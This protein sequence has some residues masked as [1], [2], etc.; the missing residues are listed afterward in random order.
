MVFLGGAGCGGGGGAS[1]D[2]RPGLDAVG[3]ADAGAGMRDAV[4]DKSSDASD[5]G[6]M[7][8]PPMT[9]PGGQRI[10][11]GTVNFISN[12][13]P[14]SYESGSTADVWCAILRP[15][16]QQV[17][18]SALFI[19]N[20][21][22]AVAGTPVA[23][24]TAAG[25]PNCL[26]LT[27]GFA[28]DDTH[29][30]G[31]QGSTLIYYDVTGTPY[32]WRPGMLNGRRLVRVTFDTGDA[33]DC[34]AAPR[35]DAV[36]CLQDVPP[37]ILPT[38]GVPSGS[39]TATFSDLLVGHAGPE[40][41]LLQKVETI[42]SHDTNDSAQRALFRFVGPTGDHIAWSTP[43]RPGAPEVLK[44]QIVGDDASRQVVA[45]DVSR[46]ATSPDFTQWA[47]LS[48]FN[49]DNA[50]PSGTLQ[51]APF[52]DGQAPLTVLEKAATFYFVK[53]HGM[54][55]LDDAGHLF[56]VVDT[57]GSSK[58]VMVPLDNGVLGVIAA[59]GDGHLAYVKSF[60]FIF[61]LVDLYVQKYDGTGTGC[62][63][64]R[65]EE[66]PYGG[67]LGPRFLSNSAALLW[68]RVTNLDTNDD[69]LKAAGKFTRTTD[70]VTQTVG[71]DIVA[72]GPLGQD[73]ISVSDSYDGSSG[74]LRIRGLVSTGDMLAP[75]DPI[76]VQTRMDSSLSLYPLLHALVYTVNIGD[77][78]DGLYF[79][80][81]SS[82]TAPAP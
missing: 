1:P 24:G 61:S 28:S 36:A 53:D 59:S 64:D 20:I 74:T 54:S 15:S 57:T 67:S 6:L 18:S 77:S 41:P 3:D 29:K 70:C 8:P 75:G 47:W 23:C 78:A 35:G 80:P 46:W 58:P 27:G 56:G 25:D 62:S 44:M 31:F 11:P 81:V 50:A 79:R 45:T 49:Y 42:V 68:A 66:V 9:G 82:P 2:S 4:P 69:R 71:S 52:P 13:V 38:G 39:T 63:L 65:S 26:L 32:A 51:V 19:M 21:S 48:G 73:G 55:I 7:L 33:H 17:G 40:A 37:V 30:A 10:L 60:D 16:L 72:Q 5:A 43:V 12:G 34:V 76:V 22:Q 14:C